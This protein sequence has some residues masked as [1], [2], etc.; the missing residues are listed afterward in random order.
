MDNLTRIEIISFHKILYA[1]THT[2]DDYSYVLDGSGIGRVEDGKITGGILEIGFVE[3]NPLVF[4]LEDGTELTANE[5][6]VFVIPPMRKLMIRAKNEGMHRHVTTE[7]V[8]DCRV[9]TTGNPE[10][11]IELPLVI[12]ADSAAKAIS[13][14]RRTV[15]NMTPA[16]KRGYYPQFADFTAILAALCGE[17]E[18]SRENTEL[19]PSQIRYCREA[20]DYIINNISKKLTVGE[21]ARAVG[22]NKNYLT[23]I[24]S[25]TVGMPII[26]YVNRMKLSHIAELMLR[27]G[28]GIR[29][30]AEQVGIDNVNYVSRMFRKYYG[31]TISEYKRSIL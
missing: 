11:T 18:Q 19:P 28:C 10:R 9:G 30:A 25:E 22:I 15:R 5:G 1:H 13:A 2:A 27:R 20:E 24:F 4:T 7:S 26:E 8:V 31:V 3:K 6:D 29:E 23:N 14:I 17:G 16:S 21:I 12:S